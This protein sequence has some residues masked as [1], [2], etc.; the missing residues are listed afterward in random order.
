MYVSMWGV[1]AV[2][3]ARRAVNSAM[4]SANADQGSFSVGSPDSYAS[5][6]TNVC[7]KRL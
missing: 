4:A 5:Q 7:A 2:L 6:V 1:S 3:G